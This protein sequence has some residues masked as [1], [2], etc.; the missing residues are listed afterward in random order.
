MFIL[1]IYIFKMIQ[2]DQSVKINITSLI[3]IK[4]LMTKNYHKLSIFF[5][6]IFI[7]LLTYSDGF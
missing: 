1:A 4:I 3:N 7:I 5:S 6:N 2:N